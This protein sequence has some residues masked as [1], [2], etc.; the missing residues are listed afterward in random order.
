MGKKVIVTILAVAALLSCENPIQSGLGNK[1]D[2][3]RPTIA[4]TSPQSI[5]D[6]VKGELQLVINAQDDIGVSTVQVAITKNAEGA[7]LPESEWV[8]T[9]AALDPLTGQWTN[10]VDTTHY[11]DGDLP[12]MIKAMDE[13]GKSVVFEGMYS[14]KNGPPEVELQIP[15]LI[16]EPTPD[17]HM[18]LVTGGFMVG[19]A[20]DIWGVAP[21]YPKIQFWPQ[22]QGENPVDPTWLDMDSYASMT[23]GEWNTAPNGR[24]ALEFRFNAVNRW[25]DP[26]L[27]LD[28]M[29]N[30]AP[31]FYR[32]RFQV[33]D[34]EADSAL[35]FYPSE[36]GHY[37][38]E[39]ISAKELPSIVM[40]PRGE[41]RSELT[42]QYHREAFFIVADA[43]H[44][45]GIYDATIQV[46]KEGE[47]EATV[48]ARSVY[49]GNTQEGTGSAATLKRT[50]ETF[51]IR[52]GEWYA[53]TDVDPESNIPAT[54]YYFGDGVYT[55][56][57]QATS[58]QTSYA[59]QTLTIYI[60]TTPP[61]INITRVQP[62]VPADNAGSGLEEF[63]VNGF[64]AVDMSS[65][66]ANNIGVVAPD[67]SKPEVMY[68]EIKY[69]ILDTYNPAADPRALY[70]N[71]DARYFD[72]PEAPVYKRER[73]TASVI[74]NTTVLALKPP[75][76][77]DN[78]DKYLYFIARDKAGNYNS[79]A[80]L[81]HVNQGTDKPTISISGFDP[82]QRSQALL[83]AAALPNKL[84]EA[85]RKL[86]GVLSDDDGVFIGDSPS[87]A[88]QFRIYQDGD[89]EPKADI[90]VTK[91]DLAVS[92]DKK[93][94]NFNVTL[95][96]AP[97]PG[98]D[99]QKAEPRLDDGTYS[100]EIVIKDDFAA[101][102]EL[103]PAAVD[104][105]PEEI[106][107]SSDDDTENPK[108]RIY[109]VLDTEPP[110]VEETTIGNTEA[111]KPHLAAALFALGGTVYDVNGLKSL[112]ITQA[113]AE[114]DGGREKIIFRE[115]YASPNN[116]GEK[117]WS[118]PA[119]PQARESA[120]ASLRTGRFTYRI[121]ATDIAGRSTL[122]TRHVVVDLEPPVLTVSQPAQD[123]WV[124]GDVAALKVTETDNYRTGPVFYALARAADPSLFAGKTT[125][126]QYRDDTVSGK[127]RWTELGVSGTEWT[128]WS[129]WNHTIPLIDDS[130]KGVEGI[131]EGLFYL[132]VAAFD[133][134]GNL[135]TNAGS[136]R[137]FGV[138]QAPPYMDGWTSTGITAIGGSYYAN[139]PYGFSFQARDSNS[140]QSAE[141][142]R[143]GVV[144]TGGITGL[145][146]TPGS[147]DSAVALTDTGVDG[148]IYAYAIIIKDV[149][150]RENNLENTGGP[151]ESA[152]KQISVR[153]DTQ[154]PALSV[155]VPAADYVLMNSSSLPVQGTAPDS[156]IP[157]GVR[158]YYAVDTSPDKDEDLKP[159]DAGFAANGWTLLDTDAFSAGTTVTLDTAM[160]EEG[161]RYIH[162]IAYDQLGNQAAP[163]DRRFF[164]DHYAPQI[165]GWTSSHITK[166]PSDINLLKDDP[167]SFSFD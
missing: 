116:K 58:V 77:Y 67:S 124:D 96:P 72:N 100:L 73:S 39:V 17:K 145:P 2:I 69:L 1:V 131:G 79:N 74:I 76:Y 57:V 133:T 49:T 92:S 36:T 154:G 90:A 44:T 27:P 50:L 52:P 101:K 41:D 32:F 12:V 126:A 34:V 56:T 136:I 140:L 7:N 47:T 88:V 38:L 110:E 128:D 82:A 153:V 123:V 55:F 119:L 130:G 146:I 103:K 35:T 114:E 11:P 162:V 166:K 85:D 127:S 81:L 40:T 161:E 157:A 51:L 106:F 65:Y 155:S 122:L 33:K 25:S 152:F 147:T 99:P 59:R 105:L 93:T 64:I 4:M 132:H 42:G 167:Y 117:T 159:E 95:P 3:N 115:E 142:R 54:N 118:L 15:A 53:H 28:E 138:D 102:N 71:V 98:D 91:G 163:V 63:T 108:R 19:I 120:G 129:E 5:G 45:T 104:A 134:A 89:P 143:D 70:D 80:A 78:K 158:V 139:G 61:E 150:D 148:G 112:I 13:S 60:D 23:A 141:I 83:D 37:E 24:I 21:G 31:G 62:T 125:P 30:L 68:R 14:V 22:S 164:V 113:E 97:Q 9:D 16:E 137:K 111:A 46:Q 20:R 18:E 29:P 8:W 149:R 165:N 48:L 66:D 6:R 156:G 84:L 86:S 151:P 87:G 107:S 94:V 160:A 121:T 75:N 109:F 144:V 26:S 43:S 10:T 135:A